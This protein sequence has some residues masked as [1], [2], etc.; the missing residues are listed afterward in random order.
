MKKIGLIGGVGTGK[1]LVAKLIQE[2]FNAYIIKAD[3]V[4]HQLIKKGYKSYDLI[5]DDFGT[6]IL[7][8]NK[9]IHRG[10]LSEIVMN[11]SEKLKRL[12][13]YTHPYIYDYIKE[14]IDSVDDKG[15]YAYLI[16][17]VPLMIESGFD[18]LVDEIL[19]V[20]TDVDIRINRLKGTRNY[21]EEKIQR[22]MDKQLTDDKYKKVADHIIYN[23]TTVE[24]TLKQIK[25]ILGGGQYE[26]N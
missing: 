22:I 3:E 11:D 19:Y 13:A 7:D 14:E 24:D 23:N 5:V 16:L 21:S 25:K 20:H 1:S 12:N 2:H 8:E 18:V 26:N 10:K 4:G 17:E 9:E 6:D 15:E